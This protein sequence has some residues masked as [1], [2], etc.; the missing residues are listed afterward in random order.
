[1]EIIKR[2]YKRVRTVQEVTAM[3]N[4]GIVAQEITETVRVALGA[5]KV[6]LMA[7]NSES[8]GSKQ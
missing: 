5:L 3:V 8:R 7:S 4:E 6:E 2:L 1:M